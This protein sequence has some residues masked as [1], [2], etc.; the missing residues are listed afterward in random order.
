MFIIYKTKFI[1]YYLN[2]KD[3]KIN[4]AEVTTIDKKSDRFDFKY[5]N[6]YWYNPF[7]LDDLSMI[8]NQYTDIIFDIETTFRVLKSYNCNNYINIFDMIRT[9][10]NY[11]FSNRK[12][13]QNHINQLFYNL[14]CNIYIYINKYKKHPYFVA[15]IIEYPISVARFDKEGYFIDWIWGD[16]NQD[17]VNEINWWHGDTNPSQIFDDLIEPYKNL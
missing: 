11:Y 8:L 7:R 3:Y 17:D 6:Y 10:I 9:Q 12:P 2:I 15:D 1:I 5:D 16:V 14:K 13:A 4:K